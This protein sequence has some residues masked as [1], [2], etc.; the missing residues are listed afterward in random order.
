[1][2]CAHVNSKHRIR[3]PIKIGETAE[4]RGNYLLLA[5]L[6]LVNSSDFIHNSGRSDFNSGRHQPKIIVNMILDISRGENTIMI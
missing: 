2:I 1:M 4:T 6:T 5:C 3:Q